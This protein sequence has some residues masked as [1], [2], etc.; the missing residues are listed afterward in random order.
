MYAHT[1]TG[2]CR[3]LA[4]GVNTNIEFDKLSTHVWT[5]IG[6]RRFPWVSVCVDATYRDSSGSLRADRGDLLRVRL[7]VSRLTGLGVAPPHMRARPQGSRQNV[8]SELTPPVPDQRI[9]GPWGEL[10]ESGAV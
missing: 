1:S 3:S 5:R 8:Q 2:S 10:G 9:T 4:Q 6:S 7:L